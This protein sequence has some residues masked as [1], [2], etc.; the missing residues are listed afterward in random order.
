[1]LKFSFH[2]SNG[3]PVLLSE[4]DDRKLRLAFGRFGTEEHRIEGAKVVSNYY[5]SHGFFAC[6]CRP[7]TKESPKL[8]LVEGTHIRREDRDG[9]SGTPHHDSC[10]FAYDGAEQKQLIRT[11]RPLKKSEYQL[12]LVKDFVGDNYKTSPRPLFIST[13][14]RAPKLA[15]TLFTLL[16]DSK[17]DRLYAKAPL[18]GDGEQQMAHILEAAKDFTVAPGLP[19][20]DW[21]ATSLRDFY[22]LKKKL[23]EAKA[24]GWNRPYGL[25]IEVFDRIK[26][27]TLYPHRPD[28]KPIPITGDLA[29][30]GEKEGLYRPPYLV[31]GSVTFPTSDAREAELYNVYAHPCLSRSRLLPVDSDLERET[32]Q[33]LIKCRDW[34]SEKHNITVTIEKPLFD[35]GPAEGQDPRDLC[36]PD[37]VMRCRRGNSAARLLVIIET[38][39]YKEA[40]YRERKR[41]MKL[42]FENI[43]GGT[44]PHPVIEH[45]K[46]DPHLKFDAVDTQFRTKVCSVIVEK[47]LRD[48]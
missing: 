21:L 2:R 37:F 18:W 30:F 38:M 6:D 48:K 13:R 20:P 24:A 23:A 42:L 7:D 33:Q 14:S 27:K 4:S 45:D 10:D 26:D 12:N 43:K 47:C 35:L 15:K 34:L 22:S 31:I 5:G 11:W 32:L 44:P 39:G 17:I 8:F 9:G 46:L 19:L 36:R 3:S 25:F 28:L 29:V 40:D 41:R 16:H 1:M